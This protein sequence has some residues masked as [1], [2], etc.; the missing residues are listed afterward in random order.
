MIT[1]ADMIS[2]SKYRIIF[3]GMFLTFFI[4]SGCCLI[5]SGDDIWWGCIPTLSDFF[6]NHQ[7]NGRYL[8][9]II[10]F[11]SCHNSF[12]RVIVYTVSF[13]GFFIAFSSLLKTNYKY[14]WLPYAL[15]I[16]VIL[17]AQ[18][19]FH[20]Q[21]FNWTSGFTN[22]VISLL[23]LFIYFNYT[24]P[25][26]DKRKPRGGIIMAV[27]FLIVG[28]CGALCIENITIYN[29]IFSIFVIIFSLVAI[30]KVTAANI[31]YFIGTLAG[32]ILMF[33]VSNYN[34]IAS[35]NDSIGLRSFE[36]AFEDIATKVYLEI[37]PFYACSFFILHFIIAVSMV[38]IYSKKYQKDV[39][40]PKY[41][42]ICI[43]AII[44]YCIYS[45]VSVNQH[46]LVI[47]SNAYKAR[48]FEG[49]FA[50]IYVVSL[51]YMIYHIVSD[52]KRIMSMIYLIS[53][54][55]VTGQFIVIS[56]INTRCFFADYVFWSLFALSL[57]I[58]AVYVSNACDSSF[59]RNTAMVAV[60]VALGFLSF[61]NISNKYVDILRI[62]FVKEQLTR[63]QN[64]VEFI[65]LP[66]PIISFDTTDMLNYD[67]D[68]II[69]NNEKWRYDKAYYVYNDIDLSV[70]DRV[71]VDIDMIDYNTAK[72][73]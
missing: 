44:F 12:I 38:F 53:T 35:G 51:L 13:I 17:F 63:K 6:E 56:P 71:R 16:G 42:K 59:F 55:V 37:I 11:Y 67:T 49:A 24:K 40:K 5:M 31:T 23:F 41:A 14:K 72:E 3:W 18:R 19:N 60:A 62:D 73:S 36:F 4:I 58:E 54:L 66:Y 10:T 61:F 20:S 64:N 22:Y 15:F 65:K 43:P 8:T 39:K 46:E 68:I 70:L 28:F 45:F 50:F 32:T 34:D 47:T 7:P 52:S 69:L 25:V 2:K 9:N 48:A 29:I 1:L 33:S 26:F 57:L 30:R 27:V 21:I